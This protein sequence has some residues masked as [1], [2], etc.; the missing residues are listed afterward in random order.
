MQSAAECDNVRVFFER[1][2]RFHLLL[3]EKSGNR[4]LA[5]EIKRFVLPLFAFVAMRVHAPAAGPQVLRESVDEHR[6]IVDVLRSGDPDY[7]ERCLV[8]TIRK[9]GTGTTIL[10][11]GDSNPKPAVA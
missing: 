2:L 9:F 6:R 4:F 1:D 10:L 5:Q 7:A 8:Y 11:S 3:C